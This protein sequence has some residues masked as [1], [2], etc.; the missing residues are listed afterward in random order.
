[1]LKKVASLHIQRLLGHIRIH[2]D[3]CFCP[4]GE[5]QYSF[6]FS[7]VCGLYQHYTLS[8]NRLLL[9]TK[10]IA[11]LNRKQNAYINI[12]TL[13]FFLVFS[14]PRAVSPLVAIYLILFPAVNSYTI[15]VKC[16]IVGQ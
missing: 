4:A 10:T 3:P 1:M 7:S 15:S 6:S 13:F 14:V 8:F 11:A 5:V 9:K 2:L 16:C 12:F